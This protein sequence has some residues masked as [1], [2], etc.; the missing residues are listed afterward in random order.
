M[1]RWLGLI[2]VVTAC[3]GLAESAQWKTSSPEQARDADAAFVGE[4]EA[5]NGE[6][7]DFQAQDNGAFAGSFA[8]PS[9]CDTKTF[10]VEAGTTTIDGDLSRPAAARALPVASSRVGALRRRDS[11]VAR[12]RPRRRAPCDLRRDGR[13]PRQAG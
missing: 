13:R 8:P 4:S 3:G 10:L 1:R 7:A 12:R 2:V 11:D 5:A 9:T 6:L